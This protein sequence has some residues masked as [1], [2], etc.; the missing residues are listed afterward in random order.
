MEGAPSGVRRTGS[1]VPF[2]MRG[3]IASPS[4][5]VSELT[6][7]IFIWPRFCPA[8]AL[9]CAAARIEPSRKFYLVLPLLDGVA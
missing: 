9:P 5:S 6:L 4:Q 8:V 3:E 2:S 7:S 1:P